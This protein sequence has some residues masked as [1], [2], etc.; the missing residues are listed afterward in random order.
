M[1]LPLTSLIL[2][3]C[4]SVMGQTTTLG[5]DSV[6]FSTVGGSATLTS[7]TTH[8]EPIY[9]TKT[10]YR[11]VYKHNNGQ[12]EYLTGFLFGLLTMTGIYYFNKYLLK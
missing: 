9:I 4:L 6:M 10:V 8:P 2:L 1:K 5:T 3:A 12:V 7:I 11:S